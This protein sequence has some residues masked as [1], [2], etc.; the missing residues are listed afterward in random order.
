MT[1]LSQTLEI[2]DLAAN[3][4]PLCDAAQ[5]IEQLQ[6]KARNCLD[7]LIPAGASV[8]LLDYP[9]NPNV[10]DSL[11]WLGSAA[12]LRSRNLNPRYIADI[13]R[14]K[15]HDIE[16]TLSGNPVILL[17]G[18]GNFGTLWP[19]Q[20]PFRFK[21]LRDFPGVPV[22][23]LP[24]SIYFDDPRAI[25]ETAQAI[26]QH[27]NFTLAVRD[28]LS[29]DFAVG[30][31]D[32]NVLLCPD[33][34]F[35]IGPVRSDKAP[36]YDRFILSR[37][38]HEKSNDWLGDL[39]RLDRGVS[40]D[41]SDWLDEG[42]PEKILNRVQYS[43][44][45]RSLLSHTALLSLCNGIAEAR[46]NRG[47]ALLERGRVVISDRLHVHILSLLMNKP[48]V[49]IDNSYKKLSSYHQAWT[50]PYR[51]VRFVANLAEALD[52][53][54]DLEQQMGDAGPGMRGA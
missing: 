28:R 29:Y 14:Y 27:G 50:A 9:V 16:K 24:Q 32:C 12:Y 3:H 49:L 17:N 45:C 4:S 6:L 20:Q 15:P 8:S 40:I 23:Q 22:V 7:P 30:H 52:A 31:F 36:R 18:G 38:D 37:T 35:F 21:V 26:R 5:L 13:Y 11:I 39:P 44:G 25:D 42:I 33:M 54:C 41:R 10:G 48:H 2:S 53:A 51:N 43:S 46:L 47:K 19:E 34:A 1:T